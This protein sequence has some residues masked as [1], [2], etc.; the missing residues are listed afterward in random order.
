[1]F[2]GWLIVTYCFATIGLLFVLS[3]IGVWSW[4][5][6]LKLKNREKDNL[7]QK[8]L[9]ILLNPKYDCEVEERAIEFGLSKDTSKEEVCK[10]CDDRKRQI[11]AINLGLNSNSSWKEID[12]AC[13]RRD[14]ASQKIWLGLPKDSSGKDIIDTMKIRELEKSF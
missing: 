7:R 14:L 10:I 3:E 11:E 6:F 12:N 2:G 13:K 1:M 8:Q 4:F 9:E 5:G